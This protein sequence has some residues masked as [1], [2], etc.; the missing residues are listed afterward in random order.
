MPTGSVPLLCVAAA[1]P[2]PLLPL[3]LPPLQPLTITPALPRHC[4]R[5]VVVLADRDKDALDADVARTLHGSGLHWVTRRGAPHSAKDLETVSAAH[6]K[7]V[8]LLHPDNDE[9]SWGQLE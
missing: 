2:A 8:I 5:D 3:P 1:W 4:C 9:V 7:T 6:A